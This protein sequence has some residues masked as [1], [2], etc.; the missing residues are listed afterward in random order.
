MA[1][2]ESYRPD[3]SG[4]SPAPAKLPERGP[5]R[6]QFSLK[7]L[8]VF[9]F[10]SAVLAAVIHYLVRLLPP[11]PGQTTTSIPVAFSLGAGALLYVI[12][13]V[14]F[15]IFGGM[16]ATGRWQAIQRHR[17]DLAAWAQRRRNQI[18]KTGSSPKSPPQSD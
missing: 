1:T 7:N 2:P 11:P 17:R 9:M 6:F 14:P 12:I 16:R 18:D 13:R 4:S 15:L 3:E 8:I 10:A 5:D